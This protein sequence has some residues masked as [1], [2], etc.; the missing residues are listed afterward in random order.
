MLD[1]LGDKEGLA[2]FRWV[3]RVEGLPENT[4]GYYGLEEL[5]H[6][7]AFVFLKPLLHSNIIMSMASCNMR[8]LTLL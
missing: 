3:G 2:G 7:H 1:G 5:L 6:P 8:T 4:A